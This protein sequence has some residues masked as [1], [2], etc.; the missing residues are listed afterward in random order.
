MVKDTRATAALATFLA[1]AGLPAPGAGEDRA[2][3]QGAGA[4]ALLTTEDIQPLAPKQAVA[5]GK[6]TSI[7][8]LGLDSCRYT[9]GEGA[10]RYSLDVTVHDAS[11]MYAG[12]TPNVI[13]QQMK[14][15]AP[16]GTV[17]AVVTDVGEA[18]VFKAD[19]P[20]YV[21]GSAYAKNRVV[22]V[23]LEGFDAFQRKDQVIA[24][25]KSAASKL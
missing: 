9:W 16:D 21:R 24:L 6:A 17:D 8:A 5:A 13:A 2:L 1:V 11:R 4:C 20:V 14:T 15:S 25:L 3:A 7:E 10:Y 19:S 22:Q 23:L 12:M 18:A